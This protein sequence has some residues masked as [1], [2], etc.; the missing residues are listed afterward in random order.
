MG[1]VGEPE[2][3]REFGQRPRPGGQRADC[4]LRAVL[5]PEP[6]G[7]RSVRMPE[8]AT[9]RLGAEAAPLRPGREGEHRFIGQSAGENVRPVG[10]R[11]LHRPHVLE[12][13]RG[14]RLRVPPGE[15][16]DPIRRGEFAGS[17]GRA[18]AQRNVQDHG[19]AP[20]EVVTVRLECRMEHDIPGFETVSTPV[21]GLDELSGEHHGSIRTHVAVARQPEPT[22]VVARDAHRGFLRGAAARI[23]SQASPALPEALGT[24][25]D[26]AGA[27]KPMNF[28]IGSGSGPGPLA[29]QACLLYIVLYMKAIQVTVDE[30][31]LKSLD[32]NAEAKRDG[33]SAVIR[34]ALAQYLARRRSA[35]IDDQIREGYRR[36]PVDPELEGWDREGMWPSE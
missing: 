26:A 13:H 31:L 28:E 23:S 18:S 29:L 22:G 3:D 20:P 14:R 35:E 34:R 12:E 2:L 10:E 1:L 6:L 17:E 33:R 27:S 8:A 16:D 15:T 5:G 4:P 19:P 24:R 32:A 30:R 9:Q 36:T 25:E 21:P 7:G 11:H